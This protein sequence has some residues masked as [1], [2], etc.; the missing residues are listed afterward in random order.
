MVSVPAWYMAAQYYKSFGMTTE[1]T[2]ISAFLNSYSITSWINCDR[3]RVL[4]SPIRHLL[5]ASCLVH[6]CIS[7]HSSQMKAGEPATW[8]HNQWNTPEDH[9]LYTVAGPLGFSAFAQVAIK[10]NT[11]QSYFG[12]RI[13]SPF[14]YASK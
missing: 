4:Y 13:L 3:E 14:G 9:S 1:E 6:A 8:T 2:F 5:R 10:N 11:R 12:V 7:F